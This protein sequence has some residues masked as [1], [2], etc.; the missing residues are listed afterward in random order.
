MNKLIYN[1]VTFKAGISLGMSDFFLKLYLYWTIYV[2]ISYK[3]TK[4][5]ELIKIKIEE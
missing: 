3:E 2:K 4:T 5:E 1:D